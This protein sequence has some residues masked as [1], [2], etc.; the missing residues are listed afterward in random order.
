MPNI[1][2]TSRAVAQPLECSFSHPALKASRLLAIDFSRVVIV[3]D[4]SWL[5]YTGNSHD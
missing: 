4:N 1:Q 2:I 5:Q 3:N